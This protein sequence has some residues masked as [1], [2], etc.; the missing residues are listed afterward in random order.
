[1]LFLHVS[2]ILA[3]AKNT[4]SSYGISDQPEHHQYVMS[5]N[6]SHP[7][8]NPKQHTTFIMTTEKLAGQPQLLQIQL[9]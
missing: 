3:K 1:M 7:P 9:D 2:A 8:T 6:C 4:N 5:L